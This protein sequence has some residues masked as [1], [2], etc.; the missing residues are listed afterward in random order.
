MLLNFHGFIRSAKFCFW[1]LTITIW[2][3]AWRVSTVYSTAGYQE[4]QGSLA[5]I[6]DRTFTPRSMDLRTQAYSLI[7]GD[8]ILRL[9]VTV[10]LFL[11]AKFSRSTVFD[12]LGEHSCA[13][14]KFRAVFM[15]CSIVM[16]AWTIN[17]PL[18]FLK[19]IGLDVMERY[20]LHRMS[21]LEQWVQSTHGKKWFRLTSFPGPRSASLN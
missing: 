19:K 14:V 5:V 4:S 16:H 11:T 8:K 2:T 10:K 15:Y 17:E 3:S 20:P 7:I 6:V 12:E 13:W 18:L 21:L 9:V 1:W